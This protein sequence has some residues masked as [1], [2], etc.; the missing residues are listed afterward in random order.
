MPLAII[1]R[2]IQFSDYD[3]KLIESD[4]NRDQIIL[5]LIIIVAIFLVVYLL[6]EMHLRRFGAIILFLTY[7]AYIGYIASQF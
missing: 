3:M 4:H 5:P 7:W 1:L 6:H 2:M